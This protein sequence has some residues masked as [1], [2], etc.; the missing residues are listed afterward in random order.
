MKIDA[1]AQN[2]TLSVKELISGIGSQYSSS[3]PLP[4]HLRALKGTHLHQ[5]YQSNALKLNESP[6]IELKNEVPINIKKK[7]DGWNVEITGRADSVQETPEK[8]IVEEIKSVDNVESFSPKSEIGRNYIHQLQIYATYFANQDISKSIVCHLVLIEVESEDT[9]ILDISYND[10]TSFIYGQ[11]RNII[12]AWEHEQKEN[13]KKK[14][15]VS[16]IPFPFR[17]YRPHQDNI[18]AE[19]SSVLKKENQLLL[20]APA[21]LGKTVGTLYPA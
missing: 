6:Y 9:E 3:S 4:R 20:L 8:I 7:I 11:I 21:G 5:A 16:S 14:K 2:L 17:E 13:Q 18:I 1:T 19:V 10:Q 12:S 15:R